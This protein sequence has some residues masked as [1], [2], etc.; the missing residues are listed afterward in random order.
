MAKK[1]TR[2]TVPAIRISGERAGRL[3]KILK[4]LDGGPATR[5][6]LLKTLKTGMRTFYRDVDLLRECGIRIDTVENGY[7][8]HDKLSDAVN[9][10][11][12]PEPNL[13]FGDVLSLMK[14]RSKSHQ[15]LRGMFEKITK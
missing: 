3:Y 15:K 14:G 12:F 6:Q 7:E 1:A 13:T 2:S 10:L 9:Q 4:V 11:P 5:A 8:L